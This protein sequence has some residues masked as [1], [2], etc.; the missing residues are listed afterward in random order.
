MET[1]WA[2]SALVRPLPLQLFLHT[3]AEQ[4]LSDSVSYKFSSSKPPHVLLS[5]SPLPQPSP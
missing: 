4:L 1:D 3:A 2:V 5:V